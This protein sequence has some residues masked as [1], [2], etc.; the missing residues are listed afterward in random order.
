MFQIYH[1]NSE[2]NLLKLVQNSIK[3]K[4]RL[5]KFQQKMKTFDE[6]CEDF[7]LRAL[8]RYGNLVDFEKV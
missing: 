3:I 8:Q 7:E 6:N 4:L 1:R 5:L 2:N